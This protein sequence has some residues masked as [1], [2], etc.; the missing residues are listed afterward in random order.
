MC[1]ACGGA[2]YLRVTV[3]THSAPP[4]MAFVQRCDSCDKYKDDIEAAEAYDGAI[5]AVLCMARSK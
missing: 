3:D 2:G 1:E 5:I 4:G